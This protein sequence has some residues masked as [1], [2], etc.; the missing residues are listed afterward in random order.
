MNFEGKTIE[1]IN[2][3]LADI[4]K[5]HIENVLKEC[6]FNISMGAKV[7]GIDRTTLY[8]KMKKYGIEK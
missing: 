1:Y 6:D 2:V 3:T 7:L 8:N 4:E 5:M